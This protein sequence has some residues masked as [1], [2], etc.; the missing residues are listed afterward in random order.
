MK[1]KHVALATLSLAVFSCNSSDKPKA[2]QTAGKTTETATTR[3]KPKAPVA[4]G[5]QR[6][7]FIGN[8]HTDFYVD[9]PEMFEE[10]CAF[11]KND[12]KVDELVEMGISLKEIYAED[13]AKADAAFAKT[14]KDKNYYDYVVIQ[15]KTPVALQDLAEYKASVKMFADKIHQNSPDAV[16]LVYELMSPVSYAESAAEFENYFKEMNSNAN[17]VVADNKN[18]M[19]YA[20]GTAIKDAY[21]GNHKY[22][23]NAGGADKLRYGKQTLHML[24]DAG[25]LASALLY[26]S[27]FDKKPEMPAEM[28]F[29]AGTGDD[30]GQEK[31]PVSKAVSNPQALLD[32]AMD[33][34]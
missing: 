28:T 14:D 31:M 12:M 30:D 10:I 23:Y 22:V 2:G 17:A 8:S 32:I 24:N 9:L 7:L 29:S 13:K 15:E 33:N 20:L 4:E 18:A 34:K 1:L 3:S 19:L 25:Y 26:A 11:N 5:A 27:I 21:K 16:I 6:I